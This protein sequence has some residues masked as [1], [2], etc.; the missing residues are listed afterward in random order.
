MNQNRKKNLLQVCRREWDF[1]KSV[2]NKKARIWLFCFLYDIN[3]KKE[4][5]KQ[6]SHFL[7]FIKFNA[8]VTVWAFLFGK[9]LH[10]TGTLI[11]CI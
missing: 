6:F 9:G 1:N 10:Y 4:V 2:P 3:N 7:D 5:L 11:S 8:R